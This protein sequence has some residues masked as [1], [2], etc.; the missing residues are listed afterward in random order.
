MEAGIVVAD[1]G[2][3]WMCNDNDGLMGVLT[4]HSETGTEGGYWAF[5]DA[6]FISPNT[7]RFHCKICG[8][9]WD[10]EKNSEAEILER[11]ETFNRERPGG[12]T[13]CD[14]AAHQF[15]LVWPEN[16]SYDGLHILEDGDF[17]SIYS[18]YDGDVVWEGLIKLKQYPLYQED[19]GGCWIH[20]D[21]EGVERT[22]WGQWFIHGYQARLKKKNK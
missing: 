4:F 3:C 20:A 11:G 1:K 7:T 13:Y 21:Q 5:Q 19:L 22:L 6:R 2:D 15:Q 10:K 16:W 14:R 17:I 18:P 9:Y 12:K 8:I